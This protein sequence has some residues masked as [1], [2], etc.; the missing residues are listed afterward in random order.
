MRPVKT[1][2]L[3][4]RQLS[5]FT[6]LAIVFPMG[7]IYDPANRKGVSHL[8]E[9]LICKCLDKYEDR[10]LRDC[11]DY[12][13]VTEFD[14]VYFYFK[15]LASILTPELKQELVDQIINHGFD[16]LT[17]EQ[18]NLEKQVVLQEVADGFED[19]FSG[20]LL[21]IY[22]KYYNQIEPGGIPE[23]I[24][25][26]TFEEA[27]QM[28]NDKFRRPLRIVEV[29]HYRTDFS[30]V[31]FLDK[32][33]NKMPI[34]FKKSKRSLHPVPKGERANIFAVCK[35][36]VKSSDYQYVAIALHMLLD[37]FNAPFMNEIRVKRGL[38]YDVSG[39][40]ER[41]QNHSILWL[42]LMTDKNNVDEVTILLKD[43]CQN[44]RKYLTPE[45]FK[46]IKEYLENK[47]KIWKYFQ[48]KHPERYIEREHA[49][50]PIHFDKIN[51]DDLV[52]IVERYFYDMDIQ[53]Y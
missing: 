29:N 16:N 21:N 9:H 2:H 46:L 41:I 48:W 45:R 15:G 27:K 13:A 40:L 20:N 35:K 53:V 42:Y 3:W 14:Y 8:M 30:H 10:F 28:Y 34:H 52:G 4:R 43:L 38:A 5:D 12:N 32:A 25:E 26:F 22:Y 1:G 51:Y 33:P 19:P 31:D 7:S 47:R 49:Q 50:L 17:E 36:I 39:D 23:H 6:S 18:F 37:G 44:V 11:I 24:Q